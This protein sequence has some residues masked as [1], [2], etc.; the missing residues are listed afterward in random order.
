MQILNTVKIQPIEAP[1]YQEPENERIFWELVAI[2][3]TELH[4]LEI[5]KG[6][7]GGM[8]MRYGGIDWAA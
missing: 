5:T 4:H 1:P 7:V 3:A 8:T 6:L 2:H